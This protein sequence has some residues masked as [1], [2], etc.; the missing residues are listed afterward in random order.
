M[1]LSGIKLAGF[2]SFVEPSS[3]PL[4]SNLTAIVGP[5]GSGK[6]NLIDAV[7]WVLGETSMKSLRGA[8]SED[9]IFN[10]SRTR[11]PAGRASV[12]LVFDNSDFQIAGPYAAYAEI[13]VR[14]ELTRDG[15]SQYYLNGQKCLKRDVTDLFLGTG[16]G[17][18]SQYAILEQGS[19]Q[20]LVDA[21]P[22]EM[23]QW[24]EEAAGISKYRERRRESETRIRQTRENLARVQDLQNELHARLEALDRQASNAEKYK[25]YKE[26]ERRLKAELLL[27]RLREL[28]AEG[29][30][31][32]GALDERSQALEGARAALVAAEQ[33]RGAAEAALRE[34]GAALNAEQGQ[35][36]EAEARLARAEQ[37]L[38]HAR[39]L[40]ELRRR[41]HDQ[42]EAQYADLLAR[43]TAEQ[44]RR[45]RLIEAV[46]A[47]TQAMNA[48]AAAEQEATARLAAAEAEA[49][50]QQS[51]WEEFAQRAQAPLL[52]AERCRAQVQALTAALAHSEQRAQRLREEAAQLDAAPIQASLFGEEA[53]L[54]KL[55]HELSEAQARLQQADRELHDLRERRSAVEGALHE[56]R[57]AQ[58]AARGRLAS[59]ETLQQAALREDDAELAAWLRERGFAQRPRLAAQLEVES[60]WET[61]VEHV[62]E[63]WLQ[64]PVLAPEQLAAPPPPAADW[65]KSGAAF[66]ADEADGAFP[67]SGSLAAKVRGPAALREWLAS[68]QTA[69]D[70][71][72][73]Q[74]L[75]QRLPPGGSVIDR[76][77]VW[78][79]RGWLRLPRRDAEH[80]GIIARGLVLQQLRAQLE[81]Q[82]RTLAAREEELETLRARQAHM[83]NERRSLAMLLDHLRSRQAHHLAARQTQAVRLE[84]LE[85][86][87]AA[88]ERELAEVGASSEAQARELEQARAQLAQ[89]EAA[90]RDLQQERAALAAALAAAREALPPLRSAAQA[91][92]A[93]RGRCQV[94][95]AA[96][97]SAAAAAEQ[98]LAAIV[99]QLEALEA[100]RA[101]HPVDASAQQEAIAAQAQQVEAARR[102]VQAA[103]ERLR[104]AR[105]A[106]EDADRRLGETVHAVHAAEAAREAAQEALQ[107]LRLEFENLRARR[108]GLEQQFAETGY[109]RA[110]LAEALPAD[111]AP[112]HWEER[113]A[114]LAR[115]IERLG[116]INLAAIEELQEARE[117]EAYLAA[118]HQD[119]SGALATL[120]EAMRKLDRETEERFKTTFDRV[121]EIFKARFPQLFGGG[122]AYLELTGGDLLETGVRVM[123]RP[124]GKRN[125]SIQVLS[126]G[127]KAMVAVALL[128]ALFQLNPA[129]FCLMDEVDAPMDDANVVRFCEVVRDM[130]RSVQFIIIT[131]N[132]IT[133]ELA[134]QLHGVTM[135]EPGV[136]RLVSVDVQQAVALAGEP[137]L[138]TEAA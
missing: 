106:Q 46:A 26:E 121:N 120:E 19:I 5:N 21:K 52:A 114:Q 89:L 70:D 104:A 40:E 77:G 66:V 65:P 23:R 115:R 9:V 13:A 29:S 111:A 123:A 107:Q 81:E 50:A 2:K 18:K 105:A 34:A 82:A 135:Q 122:E 87:R 109:S 133:M 91:A 32:Q 103:R 80:G 27:L 56:A 73:F 118:Q 59:L 28:Q 24:L 14:R 37:S 63:H 138:R 88:L 15:G 41:E 42:L 17:G 58:Q 64:A 62:L 137:S 110:E 101:Q 90:E 35:V 84:Q 124:P 74:R 36:Y 47:A 116:P 1:R 39:E 38:A 126:G 131:H 7:R 95:H 129:P 99:D 102:E 136:S 127:E 97:S 128:L 12:E 85:A 112:A 71:E 100:S 72:E 130:A 113:L 25:R 54:A 68:I 69:Q 3:L 75:A 76:A 60:G 117:R 10:G 51:R 22:E 44:E 83:E 134:E 67:A 61:A 96:D 119:V 55:A 57:Q 4:P 43:R 33:A 16:L 11:K 132:K 98:A 78:R 108:E 31:R 30:A 53:E 6:S 45:D 92:A 20:R 49:A 79:G 125:S 8:E 94:R 48:A 86:R 93:E